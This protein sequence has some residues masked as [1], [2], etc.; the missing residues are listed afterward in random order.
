[1]CES[2]LMA[3]KMRKWLQC[4]VLHGTGVEGLWATTKVFWPTVYCVNNT[5]PLPLI[6]N[7]QLRFA[8][9]GWVLLFHNRAHV[10]GIGLGRSTF[11]VKGPLRR[12]KPARPW[13]LRAVPQIP[14]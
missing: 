4:S 8:L 5:N 2:L 6:T 10:H 9:Q 11:A 14:T 1:M 12:A 7:W 3:P 13:P